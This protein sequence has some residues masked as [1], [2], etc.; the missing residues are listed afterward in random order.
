MCS[1]LTYSRN[2]RKSPYEVKVYVDSKRECLSTMDSVSLGLVRLITAS[3]KSLAW[4]LVSVL[5]PAATL[6]HKP[7]THS[8]LPWQHL[9]RTYTPDFLCFQFVCRLYF[10]KKKRKRKRSF[11]MLKALSDVKWGLHPT[12]ALLDYDLENLRAN[13]TPWPL[14]H[15]PHKVASRHCQSNIRMNTRTQPFPKRHTDPDDLPS[16]HQTDLPSLSGPG[17]VVTWSLWEIKVAYRRS[18]WAHW[19]LC[20]YTAANIAFTIEWSETASLL[21]AWCFLPLSQCEEIISVLLFTWQWLQ[22]S[23]W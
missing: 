7:F 21:A 11:W 3:S 9:L 18:A 17:L 4:S 8:P 5:Q 19:A 12:N 23:G 10:I 20:I 14:C 13:A 2:N 6:L 1:P 22:C 15:F 16:D